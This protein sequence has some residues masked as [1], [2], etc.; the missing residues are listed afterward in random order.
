MISICY[1]FPSF[2]SEFLQSKNF[3]LFAIG[4]PA[5]HM[6]AYSKMFVE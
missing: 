6:E 1:P 2:Y 3:V 5:C 4:F